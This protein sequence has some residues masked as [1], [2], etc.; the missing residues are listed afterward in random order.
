[1]EYMGDLKWVLGGGDG[2]RSFR[3]CTSGKAEKYYVPL[4]GGMAPGGGIN[5]AINNGIGH[6]HFQPTIV[7]RGSRL[8]ATRLAVMRIG[9]GHLSGGERQ[10]FVDILFE[11]EGAIAFENS[12]MGLLN[13]EMEPPVHIHT[14]PHV[15][16]QQQ[17]IRLP[18]SM[19]EAATTIVKEKLMNGILEYSQG[20]YRSHEERSD[21]DVDTFFEAK[22]YSVDAGLEPDWGWPS[23]ESDCIF[24][25][26]LED[27]WDEIR[28]CRVADLDGIWCRAGTKD[29]IARIYLK[30]YV[31]EDLVLG[32]YLASLKRPG[33]LT[34][35]EYAHLRKKAKS[36]FIRDGYLYKKGKRV[37]RRVVGLRKQKLAVVE[38]SHDEIG[39]RGRV[40]TFEH[41]RRRYQW[42]GMYTDVEEW[43]KT[44][45]EC[46]RRSQL[47]YEEA[48]H[49]TWSVMV[50]DKVGVDVVKKLSQRKL[51]KGR[52]MK[53]YDDDEL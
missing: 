47:M 6:N 18:K 8:T 51:W 49:P 21:D 20:P 27:A 53:W 50:W 37:P 7:P 35:A 17:N 11:F 48:L 2:E 3:Q 31:G 44:C 4:K 52:M 16:W 39:H 40:A 42:K 36:F 19:Q 33:G 14:V 45:E 32:K 13:P 28:L 15:P 10:L 43:V 34:D 46:Q 12:E 30:E 9:N 1:M 25:E 24:D 29:E 22:L 38:G 26:E 5:G 41:V 23:V